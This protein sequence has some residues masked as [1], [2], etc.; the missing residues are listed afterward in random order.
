[1]GE[2][3]LLRESLVNGCRSLGI[4]FDGRTGLHTRN[5][6]PE[7]FVG[8]GRTVFSPLLHGKPA[9]PL[10]GGKSQGKKLTPPTRHV[11]LGR[12]GELIS[13]APGYCS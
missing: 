5:L 7:L 3:G 11:N 9:P 4:C 1:M 13:S 8:E 6:F 12:F 2:A 10:H